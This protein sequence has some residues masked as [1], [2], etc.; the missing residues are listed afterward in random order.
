MA[1]KKTYSCLFGFYLL[2]W[3]KYVTVTG[4]DTKKDRQVWTDRE[5]ERQTHTCMDK[6]TDKCIPGRLFSSA[7][8]LWQRASVFPSFPPPRS[9]SPQ[10]L[11][12]SLLARAGGLSSGDG[13]SEEPPSTSSAWSFSR[14]LCRQKQNMPDTLIQKLPWSQEEAMCRLLLQEIVQL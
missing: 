8:T 5:R 3:I 6:Q 10:G 9:A 14:E 1:K 13:P 4:Q 11:F 7:G 2:R 12:C